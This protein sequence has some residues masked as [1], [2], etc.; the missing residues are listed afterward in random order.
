MILFPRTLHALK[1]CELIM[2]TLD[3]GK[4]P[5]GPY[6]YGFLIPKEMAEQSVSENC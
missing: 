3:E 4:V 1:A 2:A 5:R 6:G